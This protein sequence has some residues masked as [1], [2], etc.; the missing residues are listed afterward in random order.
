MFPQAYTQA[1]AVCAVNTMSKSPSRPLL[2]FLLA[3]STAMLWGVVPL[4]LK[5][6]LEA[7]DAYTITFCRFFGSWL[8]LG[9]WLLWRHHLPNTNQ[10]SSSLW[11]VLLVAA[12]GLA[13]NYLLYLQGLDHLEAKTAQVVTQLAPLL[14][15]VSG[16]YLLKER[17]S[18]GQW[19]GAALLLLGLLLFFNEKLLWLWHGH[20]NYAIGVG[21]LVLAAI[22][23]VIYVLAQKRLLRRLRSAQLM[24]LV[25]GGGSLIFLPLAQLGSLTLLNGV[26]LA[27]L[28]FC[29]LNTLIAYGAF[30]E[31]LN[32]WAATKVS[33]VLATAPLFTLMAVDLLVLWWPDQVADTPLGWL[34][35]L[36]ALLVVTG[37]I[38]ATFGGRNGSRRLAPKAPD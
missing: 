30:A 34:G 12:F 27:A 22:C 19:L 32:H 4:G 16:V 1:T 36:G 2:G 24:W 29:V 35:Y 14:L 38:V 15:L 5:V 7:M 21:L 37:S 13:S 31:S 18:R 9:L 28:L 25:Y 20:D 8:L 17:F 10:L 23:W 11:G 33:A 3:V 26:Q 6:V